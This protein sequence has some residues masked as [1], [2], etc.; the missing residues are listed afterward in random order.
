[1]IETLPESLI[2][3]YQYR[4][5][6][7]IQ[8]HPN[9]ACWVDM[10][11][12]KTVSTLMALQN[13]IDN[14]DVAHTLIIGPLRVVRK[15]W[16][17]EINTWEHIK[18]F[19]VQKIIGTPKQRIKAMQTPAEIHLIN[20]ENIVWLQ[21]QMIHEK[22]WVKKW[23]W[24]NVIIDE[25]SSFSYQSSER[26]K[27]LRRMRHKMTRMVQLTGTPDTRSLLGLWSQIHLLDDGH[28]LGF[29]ESAFLKKW[30]IPPSRYEQSNIYIP[31]HFT[32]EQIVGRLADIVVSMRAE[33]YIDVNR[34][35]FNYLRVDLTAKDKKIYKQME[36]QH[37]LR[38]GDDIARAVN[39]G[40]LANKLL[41]ICNGFVYTEH[42]KFELLHNHKMDALQELVD[43]ISGPI[44]LCYNYI[45]DRERIMVMLK[46]MRKRTGLT[47]RLLKT[48]EDEDD[49]NC[50]LIDVLLFHAKSAGHGCNIHKSGSNNLIFFGLLWSL[51]QYEQVIARLVGGHRAGDRENVIH[52][53]VTEGT[54]EDR[55]RFTLKRHGMNQREVRKMLSKYA[56]SIIG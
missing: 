7:F 39:S 23:H 52:I 53:I 54:Y 15:V 45:P 2:C 34:P 17:D 33:D 20:R 24:D 51:E 9:C 16:T 41:Q 12:G 5:S 25:S 29:S 43:G 11:L 26:Y 28:R 18:D 38:F 46:K 22:K 30:F 36:R 32:R 55:V 35:R 14:Y 56:R 3:D 27:A 31:K 13:Q 21:D 19:E 49:W 40:V 37:M 8:E 44:M 48:E 4:L 50:G 1:M 6:E 47:Y 42:P 10:G